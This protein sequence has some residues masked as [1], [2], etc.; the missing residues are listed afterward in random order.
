MSESNESTNIS[1]DVASMSS[2][3]VDQLNARVADKA[4]DRARSFI[5]SVVSGR[6][7]TFRAP[8]R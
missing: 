2:V 3:D 7:T 1:V 6:R 8:A 5:G 4:K